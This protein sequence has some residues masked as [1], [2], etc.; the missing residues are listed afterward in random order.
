MRKEGKR[1]PQTTYTYAPK[2][3][4]WGAISS[5]GK[6]YLEVYHGNMNAEN[7]QELLEERFIPEAAGIMGD[8]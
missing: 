6:A 1:I 2:V 8:F 4:V 3:Q 7:Y 5:E